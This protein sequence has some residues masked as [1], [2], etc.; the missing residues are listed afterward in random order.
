MEANQLV[1]NDEGLQRQ[2]QQDNYMKRLASFVNYPSIDNSITISVFKLARTG[3]TYDVQNRRLVC[4][5]CQ[6][7]YTLDQSSSVSTHSCLQTSSTSSND[8]NQSS[9]MRL[10]TAFLS[11]SSSSQME[12]LQNIGRSI[13]ARTSTFRQ[14]YQSNESI[15]NGIQSTQITSPQ[16]TPQSCQTSFS[17]STNQHHTLSQTTSQTTTSPVLP[18]DA[19][20]LPSPQTEPLPI[21][22]DDST[23]RKHYLQ[24]LNTFKNTDMP[25]SAPSPE[26][27]SWY[28]WRYNGPGDKVR[29][30]YCGGNLRDWED[31]DHPFTE[32]KRWYPTCPFVSII[33]QYGIPSDIQHLI[34]SIPND[35]RKT[36]M[37]NLTTPPA[38]TST[39]YR[40]EPREIKARLDRPMARSILDMGYSKD[41]VKSVIEEQMSTHGDDFSN[42][43]EMM[44]AIFRKEDNLKG[45]T[46]VTKEPLI[47][48]SVQQLSLQK[49]TSVVES[50]GPSKSD[51]DAYDLIKKAELDKQEEKTK[52]KKKKKKKKKE[53]ATNLDEKIVT[54]NNEE[55]DEELQSLLLENKQLKEDRLCKICYEKEMNTVFLPCGH[56]LACDICA[57][58]VRDCS[59]CRTYIRGTVKTFLS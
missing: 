50:A 40:I 38:V 59:M 47:P 10:L 44:E 13:L 33:T 41:L 56:L 32:H 46:N 4:Q 39:T 43:E 6:S 14:L 8:T 51:D 27:L 1:K 58:K 42:C 15:Q 12:P 16:Q 34:G 11:T 31:G 45:I 28:G 57:P 35:E 55:E 24:R 48:V 49:E 19:Y 21:P 53:E 52:R 3:F 20:V 22:T 23:I 7:T 36:R 5:V 18:L 9:S 2:T 17:N 37:T 30:V 29:C 25:S 54:I 26:M